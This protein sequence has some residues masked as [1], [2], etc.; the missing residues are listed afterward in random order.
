[1]D[2][3]TI[4]EQ[5]PALQADQSL[6]WL[7][8]A[9]TT[10]KPQSV[11]EAMNRYMLEYPANVHRAVHRLGESATAAFEQSRQRI[12]EFINAASHEEIIFT[13][14]TTDS[15]NQLATSLS[16]AHLNAGDTVLLTE[17][18]HHANI[19]PWQLLRERM[20]IILKIVAV[21]ADGDIPLETFKAALTPDV[22]LA[23]FTAVSNAIGTRLPIRDMVAAAKARDIPT[24][25]DAA[26]AI[27]T[28][29][30]DVQTI[31][32]DFL[33]FSGHKIFTAPGIGVLYMQKDWL[34][35][36]PPARGGGDM[37]RRVT[38]DN[39]TYNDPP[40]K[41][42]A[43]TPNI[44]GAIG[45]AAGVDFVANIGFDAITKH[46]QQLLDFA[47][48]SIAAID[49]VQIIGS[50]TQASAI[51]SFVIDNVHPHDVGTLLSE[52]NIAV[53]AGH[54]CAQ[55]LMDAFGVPATTR[56]SFSIYNQMEDVERLAESIKKVIRVF[57]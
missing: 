5:F 15:I 44:A 19:V 20:G 45:L 33:A 37:I 42:E 52:D 48:Q 31:G 25:I 21:N 13:F 40:Y 22:K 12:A 16:Q 18:E 34:D 55:P 46:E 56:A 6:V 47:H 51:L 36:L 9:S 28:E 2:I 57:T 7:D 4:R 26:Q 54:H 53:R 17:L 14:G 10:L 35:H 32:C 23:A 29:P 41:F 27:A 50:P 30:L 3:K 24:L 1:M 38:W 49:G 11:V 39:T 8:S 43:G